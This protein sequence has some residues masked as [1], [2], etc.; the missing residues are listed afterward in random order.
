MKP[1]ITFALNDLFKE[2]IVHV[3]QKVRPTERGLTPNAPY[4]DW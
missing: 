2:S 1:S 4:A 3:V